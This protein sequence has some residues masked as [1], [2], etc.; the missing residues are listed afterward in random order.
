M[1]ENKYEDMAG[2][3]QNPAILNP[4]DIGLDPDNPAMVG[5]PPGWSVKSFESFLPAPL[6]IQQR[7]VL[8]DTQSFC[9]Y[10]EKFNGKGARLFGNSEE[11]VVVAVLDPVMPGQPSHQEHTAALKL[12]ESPEWKVWQ[13]FCGEYWT[14]DKFVRFIENN[15][16]Q[17]VGDF[18]GAKLLEMCRDIKATTTRDAIIS[19]D[20]EGGS[21][22]LKISKDDS[23]T[24]GSSKVPF[25]EFLE[26]KLRVFRGEID[27]KF[28]A[29]LRWDL[30]DGKLT[31]AIDLRNSEIVEE[32]AFNEICDRI[33]ANLKLPILKGHYTSR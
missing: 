33:K 9:V 11:Q 21:R 32:Q 18:S 17:V 31:F 16:E 8:T 4:E 20:L 28:Q 7:T 30:T 25:P 3:F 10:V 29:R 1:S 6:R 27:F 12:T 13:A 24:S 14:R 15:M 5:L 23:V 19:E 2:Q 26:L 22:K